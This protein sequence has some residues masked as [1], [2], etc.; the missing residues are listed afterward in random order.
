[1]TGQRF[2][3][4]FVGDVGF[5]SPDNALTAEQL[6]IGHLG[7]T[8]KVGA[9]WVITVSKYIHDEQRLV[10]HIEQS[11]I[12]VVDF[13]PEQLRFRNHLNEIK[14]VS[15]RTLDTSQILKTID[16]F[17]HKVTDSNT[18]N[19]SL[20]DDVRQQL[21]E[22]SKNKTSLQ[23]SAIEPQKQLINIY[24]TFEV[25]IK[26]LNF[27][28]GKVS[29]DKFF[30]QVRK[31]LNVDIKNNFLKKEFDAVKNYF[32]HVLETKRITVTVNIQ[33][34]DGKVTYMEV[35]APKI[36][37]INAD[38]IEKL[39][40]DYV[41]DIIRK[42]QR[43]DSDKLLLTMEEFFDD[44]SDE[45]W[46]AFYQSENELAEDLMKIT[47]TKHYKN[48]RFLSDRHDSKSMKLCF[49][50]D[51]F[52]F[53]LLISGQRQFHLVWE[54]LDTE[55]A[56]YIWHIDMQR[57]N[58]PVFLKQVEETIKSIKAKGKRNYINSSQDDYTRIYHNYSQDING[59]L[60]WKDE[61]EAIVK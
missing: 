33:L 47:N 20:L 17:A 6:D 27:Q 54:T 26:D 60:Q 23:Q 7:G 59:F 10:A 18:M 48:L 8:F 41:K 34:E 16:T 39:R 55:E 57:Q 45:E 11:G 50:I 46:K 19:G 31:K 29:F 14:K 1:M 44:I 22:G 49:I 24:E 52:S 5:I 35:T 38:T 58:L 43:V 36:D 21:L 61:L 40:L 15:F 51:P 30:Q 42:R 25:R 13:S 32:E 2:I 53:V 3:I 9:Y 12:G 37:L 28:N 56:T 4:I